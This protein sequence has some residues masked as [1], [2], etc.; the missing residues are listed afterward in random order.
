[1]RFFDTEGCDPHRRAGRAQRDPGLAAAADRHGDAG[2]VAAAPLGARQH[3]LRPAR[4]VEAEMVAAARQAEA[5]DFI[6]GL[7]DMT[8]RSGYDAQVGERG[9][10]LSGGQRRR[11]AL[12]R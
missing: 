6:L 12:A 11:I 10:K 8:E 3:P 7:A 1:M 9:V 5:H 2:P 4:R